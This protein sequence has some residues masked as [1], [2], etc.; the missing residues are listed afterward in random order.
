G[1][2]GIDVGPLSE[3]RR[4]HGQTSADQQRLGPGRVT[5]LGLVRDGAVTHQI[6]S[7]HLGPFG[8]LRGNTGQFE[9]WREETRSLGAL[10]GSNDDKHDIHLALWE[11]N[12]WMRRDTKFTPRRLWIPHKRISGVCLWPHDRCEQSPSTV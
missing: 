8:E 5:D 9:P 10:A 12:S 3:R 2:R 1:Q 11:E 4:G 7:G 6:Q